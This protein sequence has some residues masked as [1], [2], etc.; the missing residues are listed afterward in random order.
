M[1][2]SPLELFSFSGVDSRSN[3][4]NYPMGRSLRCRNWVPKSSGVLELRN[5][6]STVTMTG[7]TSAT[8]YHS[9]IPYT[10]YDNSGSETPYLILGQGT[11]LRV[12]NILT[13]SVTSPT[14]KGTALSGTAGFES[15][16]ANGKIHFGNGTDQKWFDGTA[17][18]DNGLRSLTTAE[19]AVVAVY[20]GLS[21]LTAPQRSIVT[22]TQTGSGGSFSTQS[23]GGML[24]YAALF[25]KDNNE[26]GP[27]PNFL[28][29]G[30]IQISAANS[31]VTLTNL[32]A[33]P[34]NWFKLIARTDDGTAPAYFCTTAAAVNLS[35]IA[36]SGATI[37]FTTSSAHGR[38]TGDIVIVT[39]SSEPL[40]NFPWYITVTGANTF[41]ATTQYQIE[42]TSASGGTIAPILNQPGATTTA[43]DVTLTNR[44]T[45][46]VVNDANRG[47]P[48]SSVGGSQPGYQFYA[49]I[50]NPNGGGQV[51]NRTAIGSRIVPTVRTNVFIVVLPNLSATDSEWELLIGRTG[52][53][54]LLPYACADSS[55]N[56]LYALSG[57]TAL[58]V[59]SCGTVDGTSELPIRNGVIPAGLNMFARVGDRI[60]GAQTGRPTVYRSASEA[61]AN[62]GDFVGRPEQ[63]WSPDDID[64]FP[65]SEGTTGMFDEDRGA[66]YGTK[67]HGAIFSDIGTGWAWL[68]PWYGAGMA[69]RRAHCDTP[70]GKYWVTGHKQLATFQNGSPV[71]VSDEYQA[72][73]LSKIG[74]AYLSLVEMSHLT[75]VAKGIDKIVIKC[76]DSI[77]TPYQVYHDFKNRDERGPQ[78]QG[79]EAVFSSPL[80]AN[81]ILS[82][83]RDS[84]GA[85]RLWGGANTGQ[86]YQLENGA[87]DAGT[88]FSADAVYP[89]NAGPNRPSVPEFRIYGDS[90]VTL[91]IANRLDASLNST[92]TTAFSQMK[93]EAVAGE[94]GNSY[95]L[96]KRADGTK[97]NKGYLRIQ[98]TSH[99]ADGDLTLN[100]PPHV[101]LE[102]YGRI[103]LGQGL[104]GNSQ[105]I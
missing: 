31:K 90:L 26:L 47:L 83:V 101:P 29:T 79:Y 15:Y 46:L 54:G 84:A 34:S 104:V 94:D 67:N 2:L 102:T 105:K 27:A 57:Q 93:Q 55:G 68:G 13:G 12:M 87:N 19:A 6:F 80:A 30:R 22:I 25:N 42:A 61:D 85:E 4:L 35:S 52:D 63:S 9:L 103:Y 18:R 82:K 33:E 23:Q 11:Q 49:S 1:A 78:G 74:D 37:T 75:D 65:T 89:I 69:G 38:S 7:S 56:L 100:D 5:G 3:P 24:F 58:L 17:F 59:S 40:Y 16:L 88:E 44:D 98:L 45:G 60:H 86:I 96:Y 91:S 92:G 76:M 62:T 39:G 43:L 64:T 99:S 97:L 77:G 10:L 36:R 95:Y 81:Y 73:L 70:Y 71:A 14:V 21:E 41:T 72:A 8:A 20:A 28:G 53:G 51:G 50:A 66:F 48:A 32:A